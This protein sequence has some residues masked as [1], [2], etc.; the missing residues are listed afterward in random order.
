MLSATLM[1]GG[2][3]LEYRCRASSWDGGE[4]VVLVGLVWLWSGVIKGVM[5]DT[6]C[7]EC[8]LDNGEEEEGHSQEI[9]RKLKSVISQQGALQDRVYDRTL[10][11]EMV[12]GHMGILGASGDLLEEYC[13]WA[14]HNFTLAVIKSPIAISLLIIART[15]QSDTLI[16]FT[17]TN[18]NTFPGHHQT[19]LAVGVMEVELDIENMMLEEYLKYE[20]EKERRL[21][22]SSEALEYPDSDEEIVDDMYYKLPPLKPCFQT[23]QPYTKSGIV[24]P[25]ENDEVDIDCLD[26]DIKVEDVERLRQLLTTT[27]QALPKSKLVVQPYVLQIPFLN[28]V[29]VSKVMQPFT[30]QTIYTTPHNDAY[31]VPNTEPILDVPL[32]EFGYELL[33]IIVV[34]EEAFVGTAGKRLEEYKEVLY[35]F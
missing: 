20:S 23:S 4:S 24:S 25:N 17:M 22:R 26:E 19:A 33:D 6:V 31:V 16:V 27:V 18:G 29:K 3:I 8:T 35:P 14:I 28:E 5:K 9:Y 11:V 13:D 7:R 34:D 2:Y 15:I 21:W 12:G 30:S 10:L 32:E 1:T